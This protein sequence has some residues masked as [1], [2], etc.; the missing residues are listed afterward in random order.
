MGTLSRVLTLIVDYRQYPSY[1][2]GYLIHLVTGFIAAALGA[3]AIP[4][5][6]TK[7]FEAVTFLALALEQ[8][9]DVRRME[10]D[11]LEALDDV[12]T[13]SRGEAY[14]DGIAKTFE[15]RNYF[16]LVVSFT[17]GLTMELVPKGFLLINIL[18]G[19]IAGAIVFLILKHFSKGKAVGDIADVKLGKVTV[20]GSELYVDDIFVTNH[21]GTDIAKEQ[22]E[23]KG[24]AAVI[25][26]SKDRY[27][28]T[29]DNMGQRQAILF[30]TYR[31]L[32]VKRYHF[33]R[34]D[35]EGGRIIIFLVPIINDPDALIQVIRKT[36]LLESVKKSYEI[37]KTDLIDK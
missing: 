24:L 12:E 20:K 4:A 36:P 23:K 33:T 37:M 30:E 6:V 31:A 11:S 17:T 34:R 32:G 13:V 25:Y 22:V 15:A 35:Y 8:F 18:C 16:S 28:I 2:N 29:L 7:D 26:P 19:I 10:N 14:I 5:V 27:R 21:I 9:R 3:V 1:P